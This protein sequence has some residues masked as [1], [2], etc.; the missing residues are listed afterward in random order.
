M[1]RG[2]RIPPRSGRAPSKCFDTVRLIAGMQ[3]V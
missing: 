2:I 1:A 3:F